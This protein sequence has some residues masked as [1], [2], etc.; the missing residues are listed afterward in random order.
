MLKDL[1]KKKPA[2]DIIN[3]HEEVDVVLRL[4][5]EIAIS[6]GNLDDAEL[7]I[8]KDRASIVSGEDTKV[9]TVIKKIIDDAQESVSF[10]PFVKQIN[11]TH[12]IEEK[13][14][15]LKIL[16]ELVTADSVVDAYEENLYF[17]IAD[18]LKIK[19]V[20]ANQIKQQ[21]SD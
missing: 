10:Y 3:A 21:S 8:I 13:K 16:W 12:N 2:A 11:E 19:R 7:R 4:M 14:D 20:T 5:F 6:D 18:L 9:S 15:L 17:K 1:F